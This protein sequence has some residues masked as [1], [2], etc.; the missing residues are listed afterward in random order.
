ME[1][2]NVTDNEVHADGRA[3]AGE[4]HHSNNF[5]ETSVQVGASGD[6]KQEAAH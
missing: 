2:V 5:N 3:K 1:E 4:S 6:E